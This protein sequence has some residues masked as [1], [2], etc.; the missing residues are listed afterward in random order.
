[1]RLSDFSPCDTLQLA[2][3]NPPGMPVKAFPERS[4]DSKE[5]RRQSRSKKPAADEELGAV[6]KPTRERSKLLTTEEF[7]EAEHLTPLQRQGFG[8][9]VFHVALEKELWRL[10]ERFPMIRVWVW[11]SWEVEVSAE[12]CKESQEEKQKTKRGRKK[13]SL[14]LPIS[15][16]SSVIEQRSPEVGERGG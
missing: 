12:P 15:T 16:S 11:P 14:D 7:P 9:L 1:L 2:K 8:S 6:D 13:G 10:R 4:R 3:K 5:S